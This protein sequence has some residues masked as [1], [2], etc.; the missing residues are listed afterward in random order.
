MR[1]LF[2]GL[3]LT[4][5][6]NWPA[7]SLSYDALPNAFNIKGYNSGRVKLTSNDQV[8]GS[9]KPLG[10][11]LTYSFIDEQNQKQATVKYR[12]KWLTQYTFDLLDANDVLV[13][14]LDALKDC[15]KSEIERFDLFSADKSTTMAVGV[16]NL[17]GTTFTIYSKNSWNV[18]LQL[19][20]PFFTMKNDWH[21][22]VVNPSLLA[23]SNIDPNVLA[24]VISLRAI[25]P[26]TK[27]DSGDVEP[28][29]APVTLKNKALL[30]KIQ[31]VREQ[32]VLSDDD[33]ITPEVMKKAVDHL[34]SLYQ[35]Y[36]DDAHLTEQQKITRF[37]D[38]GCKYI[39]SNI[40]EDAEKKAILNFLESRLKGQPGFTIGVKRDDDVRIVTS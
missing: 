33:N 9:L 7:F 30:E 38:F 32:L 25:R 39:Q 22:H 3:A 27:P 24:A 20:R 26:V 18:M 17:L 19:S 16:K 12:S 13:G 2:L 5:T 37:V 10:P 15:E 21:V 4:I 36:Y 28:N 40:P 31:L 35:Q 11:L 23:S 34:E 1:K 6:A 29:P 8:L 14:H